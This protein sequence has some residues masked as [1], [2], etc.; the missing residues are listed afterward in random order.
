M[1]GYCERAQAAISAY[2]KCAGIGDEEA[3]LEMVQIGRESQS[4]EK[5]FHILLIRALTLLLEQATNR[6]RKDSEFFKR[7]AGIM[8]NFKE[9]VDGMLSTSKIEY[10]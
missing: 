8:A 2:C 5:D 1:E 6:A 4:G 9:L 7:A 10:N 3:I